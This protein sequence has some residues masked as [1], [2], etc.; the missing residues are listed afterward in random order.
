MS[1]ESARQLSVDNV[2]VTHRIQ[3]RIP[4]R[5]TYHWRAFWLARAVNE[6]FGRIA[7]RLAS[8]GTPPYKGRVQLAWAHPNG[9]IA[10]SAEVS[11]RDLRLA[12]HVFIGERVIV[13]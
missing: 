7:T 11:R 10:P 3:L 8:W 5:I 9:Y 1:S 2:D 6:Q 12:K 13:Y 4:R